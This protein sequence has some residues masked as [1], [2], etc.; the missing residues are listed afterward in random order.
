MIKLRQFWG[1]LQSSFW[2]MPSLMVAVSM[3][4]AVVLIEVESAGLNQWLIQ[5]PRLFGVGAEGARQMLSTLAGSMMTV[6][7]ITFSM[8]L[9][10]LVL[11]SGQYTSRILR[12][13]M[14]NSVTQ[15]TLGVFASIFAYCLIVLRTI[16]GS[17][18]GDEFVP[19][20]AVFFAFVMSLGGVG[21]LIYFIH[22]IALSIQASSIIASV[23]QE[24]NAA[25]DKLLPIKPDEEL[26]EDEMRH[27]ILK[28]LDERVWYPVPAARSGYVLGVNNN[29]LI[30]LAS[31]NR[32]IV[33]MEQGIGSFIVQDT[34]LVSL[35]LT[36][37]PEQKL[38]DALNTAYSIGSHR[39]VDQDP[40]FGIRQIVDMAIKALSPGVN[41]TSTA[42]MCVDYLT[43]IMARLASR[44]FPPLYHYEGDTLRMVAMVPSFD[45]LLAD[46]FDQIRSS[47]E[48]N[49]AILVRML[50]AFET[51]GSLTIC[52][53][54]LRALDQQLQLIAELT[55]RCF[56]SSYDR[57]R[58]E[59]RLSK[60]RESLD[61]QFALSALVGKD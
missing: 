50:G 32:T 4:L 14:R 55:A 13:F 22:H 49:L 60:V 54:R 15:A 56:E 45:S 1:N 34:A 46:A 59:M 16:R 3:T 41:D 61:G 53:S 10:A 57:A 47:A 27:P 30:C 48:K 43:S 51:I 8:T 5:W 29:T 35:A 11:A 6:M 12:N 42:V 38:I 31:D 33:R 21:V 9:L 37:P 17:G 44:Q 39:T 40:T 7:G 26:D 36:Y 24:T 2:F 52:P 20:L 23:A 58:L 25:I 28:S 19:S 18:G